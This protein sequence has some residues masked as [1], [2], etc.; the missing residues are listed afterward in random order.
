MVEKLS[1]TEI[2]FT[3]KQELI[4]EATK[5]REEGKLLQERLQ[6]LESNKKGVSEAVYQ[7]VRSD[8]LTQLDAN[9]KKLT[10][11][12][13]GLEEELL[14]L[15]EK[16]LK[17]E[18]NLRHRRE[19]IEESKLRQSLGEFSEKE[20]EKI[21]KEE[22]VEI[23][24]LEASSNQ[25]QEILKNLEALI[26]VET[27][28]PSITAREAPPPSRVPPRPTIQTARTTEPSLKAPLI[29]STSKVKADGGKKQTIPEILLLEEGKVIQTIP[30]DKNIQI[31]R[32][33]ANDIVLK[34]P[35]A[36][37]QHAEIQIVGGQYILLDLES[38][39]GT[40]VSGQK[41]SE[42]KLKPNDEIRIG[43]TVMVFKAS[44]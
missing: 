31:G 15:T 32:S 44:P 10:A 43:R 35:K 6:R 33:P 25:M 13:K 1:D 40:F 3:P 30:L 27:S 26:V 21:S 34:D 12:R 11:L 23:K 36:S 5:I 42:Y 17:V 29:E 18:E 7:K 38:S 24:R 16:K 9:Q 37:R 20:L 22:G 19:L 28:K 41:I 8:Y 39:N 4:E 14:S 2:T